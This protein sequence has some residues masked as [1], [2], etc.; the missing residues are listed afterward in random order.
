M[1][2]FEIGKIYKTRGKGDA[3]CISFFPEHPGFPN[4]VKVDSGYIYSVTSNGSYISDSDPNV[5]DI[6]EEV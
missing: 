2:N 5:Y 1:I 3:E 6:I 4:V